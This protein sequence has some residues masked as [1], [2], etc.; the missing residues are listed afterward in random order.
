MNN[1]VNEYSNSINKNKE[2]ITKSVNILVCVKDFIISDYSNSLNP[3]YKNIT[4]EQAV[5]NLKNEFI[6]IEPRFDDLINSLEKTNKND[7]EIYKIITNDILKM[8]ENLNLYLTKWEEYSNAI[9]ANNVPLYTKLDSEIV[10]LGKQI[11]AKIIEIPN[12][13]FHISDDDM[14]VSKK[15]ADIKVTVFVLLFI[16][17]EILIIVFSIILT[18]ATLTPIQK[19]K[20]AAI[21]VSNGD[22]SK[23]I[24]TNASD[25]I[26]ELTNAIANMSENFS[27]I[28]TD[29]Y[30]LSSELENGNI[31]YRIEIDKYNGTFKEATN[32]INTSIATLIDDTTYILDKF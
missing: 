31:K 15:R 24:R 21:K 2:I 16:V 5:E 20:N 28:L 4:N 30:K 23:N 7:S 29:V 26:G 6:E 14:R 25:E 3:A 18:K 22:L 13:S 27:D 17:I 11:S 19:L 12:D 9:E 8:R 1:V 10:E 32:G